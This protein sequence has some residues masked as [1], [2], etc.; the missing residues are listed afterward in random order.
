ML[1]P[2]AGQSRDARRAPGRLAHPYQYSAVDFRQLTSVLRERATSL[3]LS[4]GNH[5]SGDQS[6]AHL[7]Q[8]ILSTPHLHLA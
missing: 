8:G 3:V 2:V 1:D 4:A 7:D 6:L 5:L